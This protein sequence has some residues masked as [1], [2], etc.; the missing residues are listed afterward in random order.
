MHNSRIYVPPQSLE[1]L[2]GHLADLQVVHLLEVVEEGEQEQQP[3]LQQ[4]FLSLYR[5]LEY[6]RNGP[7]KTS[8]LMAKCGHS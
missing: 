7:L 1:G 4:T 6:F 8:Y 2:T 5:L 3:S